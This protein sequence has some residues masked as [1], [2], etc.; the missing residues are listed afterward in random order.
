MFTDRLNMGLSLRVWIKKTVHRVEAQWLSGK[1]KVP[2]S[3]VIKE[4]H[5]DSFLG[6]EKKPKSLLISLKK[7]QL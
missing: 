5:A 2:D 7:V 4:G 6:H 3:A 1:E